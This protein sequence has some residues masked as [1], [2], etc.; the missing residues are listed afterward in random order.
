MHDSSYA[1]CILARFGYLQPEVVVQNQVQFLQKEIVSM[2]VHKLPDVG[3]E[4]VLFEL[5]IPHQLLD[6]PIFF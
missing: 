5:Q 3:G 1:L 4:L 6:I 2:A